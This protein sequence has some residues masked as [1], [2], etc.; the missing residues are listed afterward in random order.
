MLGKLANKKKFNSLLIQILILNFPL[1]LMVFYAQK[2]VFISHNFSV[3]LY[4]FEISRWIN[5]TTGL[6][7]APINYPLNFL[8]DLFIISLLSPLL[9]QIMKRLPYLGLLIVLVIYQFNLDGKLILRNS[10]LVSFYIGGLAAYQK[11]DLTWLDKY[12]WLLLGLLIS[13]C[14]LIVVFKIENRELL[15]LISP[16]LF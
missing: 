16:F 10:M 7:E 13:I 11:W 9:W 5:A 2:Y 8:R 14:I 4:L 1:V 3:H 12:S 15:I 6:F